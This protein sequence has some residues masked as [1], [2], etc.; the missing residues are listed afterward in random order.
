MY[1]TQASIKVCITHLSP[2]DERVALSTLN[3][4]RNFTLWFMAGTQCL[5][6]RLL[7]Q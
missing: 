1:K 7:A 4:K 2:G 3:L 6:Q 5:S